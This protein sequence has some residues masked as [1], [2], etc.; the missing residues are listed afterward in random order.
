MLLSPTLQ[1]WGKQ[2]NSKPGCW[3]FAAELLLSHCAAEWML[4]CTDEHWHPSA[5]HR[6]LEEQD[7]VRARASID[8]LRREYEAWRRGATQRGKAWLTEPEVRASFG[9]ACVT[10]RVQDRALKLLLASDWSRNRVLQPCPHFCLSKAEQQVQWLERRK[11]LIHVH[12]KGSSDSSKRPFARP[13]CSANCLQSLLCRCWARLYGKP[14]VTTAC[15]QSL[16]QA[17]WLHVCRCCSQAARP[18]CCTTTRL[19]P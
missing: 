15:L 4:L 5:L 12:L 14:A 16:L 11:S 9:L 19:G 2:E 13:C 1:S 7:W 8:E 3:R 6:W 17:A 10:C 18:S